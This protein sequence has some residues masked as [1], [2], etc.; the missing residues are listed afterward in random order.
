MMVNI[1]DE[2][3][4]ISALALVNAVDFIVSGI[5]KYLLLMMKQSKLELWIGNTLNMRLEVLESVPLIALE[6]RFLF[7]NFQTV[8]T[9]KV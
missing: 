4:N 7:N 3:K 6:A 2:T 9:N 8:N 1:L 5:K